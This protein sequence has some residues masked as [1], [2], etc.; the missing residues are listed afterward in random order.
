M[1]MY[2]WELNDKKLQGGT[3]MKRL[4]KTLIKWGPVVYP[5]YKK[6]RDKK[7]SARSY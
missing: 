5:I 7:R 1:I 6:Y 4:I 3:C 2:L